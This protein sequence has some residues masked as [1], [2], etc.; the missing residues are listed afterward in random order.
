MDAL[1]KSLSAFYKTKT[2]MSRI[3]KK[4]ST[5]KDEIREKSSAML[6]C[7]QNPRTRVGPYEALLPGFSLSSRRLRGSACGASAPSLHL[8]PPDRDPGAAGCGAPGWDGRSGNGYSRRIRTGRPYEVGRRCRCFA[9]T[10][11]QDCGGSRD[12]P[13][14][15]GEFDGDRSERVDPETGLRQ[16][17]H[18]GR[19]QNR[20]GREPDGGQGFPYGELRFRHSGCGH[21]KE[22]TG[23]FFRSLDGSHFPVVRLEERS[24]GACCRRICQERPAVMVDDP[25]TARQA[26]VRRTVR[27]GRPGDCED[28]GKTAQQQ[29][30]LTE[31]HEK[32]L[33]RTDRNEKPGEAGMPVF[34]P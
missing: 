9:R 7:I 10:G 24:G 8:L 21:G 4:K 22:R 29:D 32:H 13:G 12:S 3:F 20:R 18:K 23:T 17:C 25:G 30:V 33:L 5:K 11:R 34:S 14:Q 19:R 1:L 6:H 15:R 26:S 28:P 27:E 31:H 2:Y 16:R